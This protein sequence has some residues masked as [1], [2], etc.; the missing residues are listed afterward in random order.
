MVP[1][2]PPAVVTCKINTWRFSS[3]NPLPAVFNT[4][5]EEPVKV[6]LSR[7]VAPFVKKYGVMGCAASSTIEGISRSFYV[8]SGCRTC[9]TNGGVGVVR[10]FWEGAREMRG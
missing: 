2:T 3:G 1:D 5:Q 6:V 4:Y 10:Q 8:R 9:Q 7:L